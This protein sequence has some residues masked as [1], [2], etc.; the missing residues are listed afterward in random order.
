MA[1][2]LLRVDGLEKWRD[3]N[4]HP[5]AAAMLAD[6]EKRIERGEKRI[7]C[8]DIKFFEIDKAAA[9][10]K[11]TEKQMIIEA[12]GEALRSRSKSFEG[13]IRAWGPYFAAACALV[14]AIAK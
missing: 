8:H 9:V 13:I 10:A 4:G 6:H 7:G 1:D 3:G 2:I 12:V 14:A 11:V 5:G